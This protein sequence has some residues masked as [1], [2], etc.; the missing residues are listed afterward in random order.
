MYVLLGVYIQ[1]SQPHCLSYFHP[2]IG[3][4]SLLKPRSYCYKGSLAWGKVWSSGKRQMLL[5]SYPFFLG[6]TWL[7]KNFSLLYLLGAGTSSASRHFIRPKDW[8]L[9][10]GGLQRRRTHYLALHHVPV[11]ACQIE[12]KPLW[13]GSVRRDSLYEMIVD[14]VKPHPLSVVVQNASKIAPILGENPRTLWEGKK[15]ENLI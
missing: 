11:S 5:S 7:L 6:K 13:W 3:P 1:I 14:T 4:S 2:T 9:L 12:M 8:Y 10:T 15:K